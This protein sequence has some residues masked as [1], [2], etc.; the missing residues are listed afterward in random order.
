M[1]LQYHFDH[2]RL[3]DY[4]F[5]HHPL[6]LS[7][8]L[9]QI[10]ADIVDYS[11]CYDRYNQYLADRYNTLRALRDIFL[12]TKE[13]TDHQKK[14]ELEIATRAAEDCDQIIS[15]M[16]AEIHDD[17]IQKLSVFRLYMDRI[18][19]AASDPVEIQSLVIKM[20]N[21]FEHVART[22]K[23]ISRLLCQAR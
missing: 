17:L 12:N 7:E 18:E 20:R 11:S 6:K 19:R 13:R 14:L 2:K 22:V 1:L 5:N 9:D 8:Q 23:T 16:G 21:D 10:M 15:E 4:L 3:D